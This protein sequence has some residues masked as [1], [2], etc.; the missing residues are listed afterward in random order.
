MNS[1]MK[2]LPASLLLGALALTGCG[3]GGSSDSE[4]TNITGGETVALS[5][6]ATK[7]T[8]SGAQVIVSQYESGAWIEVARAM[9]DDAG[10][11][12]V[13]L[14]GVSPGLFRVQ[15][16][17]N[18]EGRTLMT[19][20]WSLG[21]GQFSA[22]ALA[23]FDLN[24][25][26]LVNFGES[27]PIDDDFELSA[28]VYVADTTQPLTT[29]VSALTTLLANQQESAGD[30]SQEGLDAANR[31]LLDS[32]G[33]EGLITDLRPVSPVKLNN[34]FDENNPPSAQSI[35]YGAVNAGVIGA[36]DTFKE[37]SDAFSADADEQE[38]FLLDSETQSEDG[39][40]IDVRDLV[41]NG[42]KA[43]RSVGD[44]N[45]VLNAL[46]DEATATLLARDGK[47]TNPSPF[48][49]P[50]PPKVDKPETPKPVSDIDR[51]KT[52]LRETREAF[53]LAEEQLPIWRAEFD[54]V[55]E[56][57]GG[58]EDL[59]RSDL[60]DGI[61]ALREVGDAL[62]DNVDPE[63]LEDFS[64]T[65]GGISYQG[66]YAESLDAAS[67]AYTLTVSAVGTSEGGADVDLDLSVN[68]DKQNTNPYVTEN[69]PPSWFVQRF[70][71]QGDTS[72]SGSITSGE[73]QLTFEQ[74]NELSAIES[75]YEYYYYSDN[76]TDLA[77]AVDLQVAV[78]RTG[79]TPMSFE[80][81]IR[82]E[83]FVPYLYGEPSDSENWLGQHLENILIHG[84]VAVGDRI[85][86]QL[87]IAMTGVDA[88]YTRYS[89]EGYYSVYESGN[90]RL[91]GHLVFGASI[92][93]NGESLGVSVSGSLN[94]WREFYSQRYRSYSWYDY[95]YESG[96]TDFAFEGM[97]FELEL[98]DQSFQYEAANIDD[99]STDEFCLDDSTLY[100]ITNQDGISLYFNVSE[101]CNFGKLT[102]GDDPVRTV[103]SLQ[104][105]DGNW[106]IE[107]NDG[108][109]ETLF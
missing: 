73:T 56:S 105:R 77:F 86:A 82:A 99:L 71:L 25:D 16:R 47:L 14:A 35:L 79:S 59:L 60:L 52:F 28:W 34:A 62:A 40:G 81:R 44:Q 89:S 104:E 51:A 2:Y 22:D 96:E 15:I 19:C 93:S 42:R 24:A 41:V 84:E 72:I 45:P 107:F 108:S 1:K 106:I 109:F 103:G 66:T 50:K 88:Y 6:S 63:A 32:L 91:A 94:H 53:V 74:D 33:L 78:S 23:E 64:F 12:S 39:Q 55:G 11:Y 101:L 65:Q 4:T 90:E 26:N 68:L 76:I 21:C 43:L 95:A 5:G 13:S 98:G 38:R 8:L 97:S 9:T 49:P 3:G 61:V 29:H 20:D 46:I 69:S 58:A 83:W 92:E 36:F 67:E 18:P 87:N 7:G 100:K 30:F 57:L 80:G 75:D 31:A 85:A 48:D 102:I 54:E 27:F 17:K 70:Y 37:F 10:D